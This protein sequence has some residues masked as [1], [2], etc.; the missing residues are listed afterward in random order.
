MATLSSTVGRAAA[1]LTNS[2]VKGAAL[3]LQTLSVDGRVTVD[4]TFTLGSLTN[5]IVRFYGSTDDVTYD[6]IA[7][8]GAVLGETLTANAE[9]MY[10][11]D[12]PGVRYFKVGVTGTDTLTSSSCA[13]TYRYQSYLTAAQTDGGLRIS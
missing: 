4:L 13:Y 3:D 11:L 7:V 10:V 8:N 5:M 9:R 6:P 12:L 1:I 2:E